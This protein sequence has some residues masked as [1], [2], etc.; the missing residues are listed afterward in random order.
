MVA[1]VDADGRSSQIFEAQALTKC[2]LGLFSREQMTS[3]LRKLDHETVI[4]LLGKLNATWSA[5]FERYAG[6]I[7]L[8]FRER[9]EMVFKDLGDRFG[10]EDRRGTLVI[11]ELSQENLAEMI[12][13]SRPMVSKVVGDMVD[14]G[15]LAR[16]EQQRFILLR[17]T[18]RQSKLASSSEVTRSAGAIGASKSPA[19]MA[20]R[21]SIPAGGHQSRVTLSGMKHSSDPHNV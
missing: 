14:E 19:R 3:L 12:G 21:L 5:L 8:S 15:L 4:Q 9:L 16:N 20:V 13:S 17:Q 10:V 6:F 1:N 7:G 18:E 2:S 11:L